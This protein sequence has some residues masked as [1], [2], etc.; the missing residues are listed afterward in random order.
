MLK[1]FKELKVWQKSYFLCLEIYR[2]TEIEPMLIA[3]IKSLE[4]KS[5]KLKI[6]YFLFVMIALIKSLEKK[7]N[8]PRPLGSSNT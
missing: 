3:L 7:S 6:I 2:I 8:I 1:N 5:N 4:K